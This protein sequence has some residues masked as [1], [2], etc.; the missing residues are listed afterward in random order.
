MEEK[1]LAESEQ[2]ICSSPPATDFGFPL[3]LGY[4]RFARSSL[5]L[6]GWSPLA[7]KPI[8]LPP[9]AS[10]AE[11]SQ[12]GQPPPSTSPTFKCVLAS[13]ISGKNLFV[14]VVIRYPTPSDPPVPGFIPSIRSTIRTW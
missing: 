1:K 14:S 12:I 13:Q 4:T 2:H 11:K 8:T 7:T 3:D 10:N 9:L 6:I 5:C